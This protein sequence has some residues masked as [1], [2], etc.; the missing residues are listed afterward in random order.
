MES[1]ADTITSSLIFIGIFLASRPP[2][3]NHPYGHGR[4]EIVAGLLVGLILLAGGFGI[5]YHALQRVGEV[6]PP[7]PLYS[8]W[9]LIASIG[10]K[11]ILAVTRFYYGRLSNSSALTGG[12]LE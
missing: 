5:S 10:A 7:P 4:L 11:A 3:E 12:F 9:P 1:A 8:I 6:H 2:D